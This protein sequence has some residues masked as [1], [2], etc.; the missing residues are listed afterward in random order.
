LGGGGPVGRSATRG[1]TDMRGL[2]TAGP[3]FR[4][5]ARRLASGVAGQGWLPIVVSR[6]LWREGPA[7]V[8]A[9]FQAKVL[10]DTG[11]ALLIAQQNPANSRAAATAM[12]VRRLLRCS[13]RVQTR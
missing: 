4:L 7:V 6:M 3:G 1:Q 8:P 12:I 13:I 5:R 2:G 10:V 9:A 11:Q